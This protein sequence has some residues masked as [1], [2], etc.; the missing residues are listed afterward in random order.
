MRRAP[1]RYGEWEYATVANE[2][3]DPP[4]FKEAIKGKD[5]Q[6]W[7]T[8]ADSEFDS[9]NNNDTWD[10]VDLPPGKTVV[11]CKWV[12]KTKR[13]SDGSIEKYKARLVAQG[14]S[15][16]YGIDYDEVFAPVV[17][18]SSIRSLLALAKEFNLEVHQMDVWS[19]Y[20]NGNLEKELYMK[21]PEGYIDKQRPD[22]V[23]I[24]LKEILKRFGM[25][26]GKIANQ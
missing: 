11:G 10:L 13:N 17:K 12:L 16:I 2:N 25:Q 1:D 22:N 7:M 23:C 8:A 3:K 15:Q 6:H 4:T 20:L 26:D 9:L 24:Y 21:Q 5:A 19:A 14:Y 18:Y